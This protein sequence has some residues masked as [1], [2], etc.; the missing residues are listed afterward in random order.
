MIADRNFYN[1]ADWCTAADTGAALLRRVKSDLILEPLEFLTDGSCRSV[2]V[3]PKVRGTARAK[4]I[5]AAR[6]GE[7]LEAGDLG[8]PA[9]ALRDQRA[10]LHRRDRGRHRS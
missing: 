2:V 9:H 4:I 10:D 5:E 6:A 7:D 1:W 8:L 3:S